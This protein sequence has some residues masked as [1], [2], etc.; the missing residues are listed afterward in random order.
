MGQVAK[1]ISNQS[2]LSL[3]TLENSMH[4]A[5]E[6]PKSSMTNRK[7]KS[8]ATQDCALDA[9]DLSLSPLVL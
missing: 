1:H 4:V 8:R 9:H 7:A 2:S 6:R 5:T 3:T